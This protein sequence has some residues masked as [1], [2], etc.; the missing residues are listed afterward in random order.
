MIHQANSSAAAGKFHIGAKFMEDEPAAG[1][2]QL[3]PSLAGN[4]PGRHAS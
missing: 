3:E 2:R 1:D 4:H